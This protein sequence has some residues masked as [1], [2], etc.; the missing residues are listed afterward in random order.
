MGLQ[1]QRIGQQTRRHAGTA[2]V[3]TVEQREVF[4]AEQLTAVASQEALEGILAHI[5]EVQLVCL[6][7]AELGRAL[8]E[9]WSL[10]Q[11]CP[12]QC[13]IDWPSLRIP[14]PGF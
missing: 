12:Q 10:Q 7:H 8:S 9:H 6:K 14:R 1:Q 13:S 5:V 11:D 3:R 2:L 4:V